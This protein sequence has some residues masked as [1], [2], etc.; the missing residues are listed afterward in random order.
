MSSKKNSITRIV[1]ILCIIISLILSF[2]LMS[3]KKSTSAT[4][5]SKIGVENESSTS[6]SKSSQT[7][8]TTKKEISK[9][10]ITGNINILTGFEIS[11]KVLNSRPFAIMI[12]N[13]P[14][15]RPQSGLNKA[16]VVIEAVDEGGITRLIGV[17]S[18]QKADVIG[19]IRS[20]RQYY[21]ELARMFDPIYVFWGTYPEGYKLIENMDMDVLT[22]LGDNTGASS[23]QANIT[24]GKDA[25]RDS[26]RVA[27]HNAYSSTE[28]L[29][30]AAKNNGYSLEGGQSPFNFKLDATDEKRGNTINIK[31]DFSM[32]SFASDFKYD[33][34][35][36]K[37]L[38]STGG[39]PSI[40]RESNEQLSFNNV[41]A[42]ITD[43]VNSGDSAGHMIVRTTG[44]GKA[45]FFFD[46]NVIEGTW[47]RNG[48]T[49]SMKFKD[50]EGNDVL[51]NRGSTYIGL[52]QGTDRVI[53]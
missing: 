44:S 8:E 32:A 39:Q 22:P 30:A 24:D 4:T 13:A 34:S 45:F 36:N 43:I 15:A 29:A 49:E 14:E 33:K 9:L 16:D 53:Y 25:W 35:S 3:C 48:V 52:V 6:A 19:P 20:A 51:F 42:L 26:S 28:K 18:S 17:F 31:I 40:D 27:P 46:G 21:A 5:Q 50:A 2:A 7:T 23:I 47:E 37:Y 11:D 12:N 41:I 10:Q 1:I 38:K